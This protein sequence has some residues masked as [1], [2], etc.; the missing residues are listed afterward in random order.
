[1]ARLDAEAAIAPIPQAARRLTMPRRITHGVSAL[2]LVLTLVLMNGIA[3]A[4]PALPAASG[5]PAAAGDWPM[6]GHDAARTNYNPAETAISAANVDQLV[7]RWEYQ[8]GSGAGQTSS[9]PSVAGGRVYIGSSVTSGDNFFALDAGTGAFAWSADLGYTDDCWHVG[10]GA[11]PAIAGDLVVAGGGN[12]TYYGLDAATG[13]QRWSHP[14]GAGASAFA[15]A[16]PLLA[17]GRAYVG[18]ASYCDNPSVQGAVQALDLATG[19]VLANQPIVRS[20]RAGGGVWNSPALSPDGGTL[21]AA[22][23][24][25]YAGYNGPYTRAMVSLDPAGLAVHEAHQEGQTNQDLDFGT[26]P[27]I[28]HDS[29]NR[30]LVGANHKDGTFYAYLLSNINAGPVWSRDTGTTVGF[31]PAYDPTYGNGGTLF[32]AGGGARLYAV[33]P[34]TGA[35]RRADTSSGDSHG[36]MA[37]ANG[38][39]FLNNGGDLDIRDEYTGNLLR[40]LNPTH[41][42]GALSG[43]AV[44]NGFIYWLS[45]GY[46]NAWSLPGFVPPTA[47][48]PA[49]TATPGGCGITFSDVFPTDY[50]YEPVRYL[51]CAGILSGYS[52]STFRPAAGTTRGQMVKII[53]NAYHIPAYTPPQ[54]TFS[55]VPAAHP[56]YAP[57]EAAVHAGII[58]GYADGTFRPG[59]GV[60]RGQL[61]KIVVNAAG[62]PMQTPARATFSDV[63]PGSPFFS[64]IETA[65]CHG[66]ISG[67][68]DGSFRPGAGATRG[69]ISK[70]VYLALTAGSGCAAPAVSGGDTTGA[71]AVIFSTAR[72]EHLCII[73]H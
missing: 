6:Y 19:G 60:T 8:I 45:G 14:L 17:N 18:V 64:A 37:I 23:G 43:V 31:M 29:Q 73:E 1:M 46:L 56:F 58:S 36:N 4:T 38:L 63:P 59:S 10:I 26:T 69:Q 2:T 7:Q 12:A 48:P 20:G 66:I 65:A 71:G 35:D 22:T 13:A 11:T 3:Q 53:A 67:Y 55:D 15:W 61:A 9:A 39:I 72:L 68:A 27:I 30:T 21:V 52:D 16:S 28:F 49:A 51:Y 33:D 40:T 44:A 62:W 41:S 24:E 32:I 42:G 25:D 34:A 57:I 70:I 5:A 50:Y 54:P 47:T